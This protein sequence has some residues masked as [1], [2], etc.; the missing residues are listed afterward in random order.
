M[1]YILWVKQPRRP[2]G[3]LYEGRSL[4]VS[5]DINEVNRVKAGYEAAFP[6]AQYEVMCI[7]PMP[8]EAP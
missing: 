3:F 6:D 5:S 7:V 2:D 1:K 4:F 8:Q